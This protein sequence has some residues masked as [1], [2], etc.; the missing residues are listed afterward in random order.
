MRWRK[1]APS[2]RCGAG[3]AGQQKAIRVRLALRLVHGG[4]GGQTGVAECYFRGCVL[5][6]EENQGRRRVEERWGAPA[7][8][9]VGPIEGQ[10]GRVASHG[11]EAKPVGG[12][13]TA[14]AAYQAPAG[15][16]V[17]EG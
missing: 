6:G 15:L 4:G 3:R 12:E 14:A 8:G 2:G 10:G 16:E 9:G 11:G 5:A 1:E 7:R 13:T 17:E